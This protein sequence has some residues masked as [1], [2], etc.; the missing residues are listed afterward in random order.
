MKC[1][2]CGITGRCG[3]FSRCG[4]DSLGYDK[5]GRCTTKNCYRHS[6]DSL[7]C[8]EEGYCLT[9]NDEKYLDDYCD[10]YET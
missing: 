7:N 1:R 4:E 2:H 10:N 5:E 3:L 8:D 6:V 9:K